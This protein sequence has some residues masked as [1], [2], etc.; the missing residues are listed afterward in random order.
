MS[1]QRLLMLLKNYFFINIYLFKIPKSLSLNLITPS[2]S[3]IT[4]FSLNKI[5]CRYREEYETYKIR[6]FVKLDPHFFILFIIKPA[7]QR[8]RRINPM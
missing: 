2:I 7:E 6:G 4:F 5:R 8:P 1:K 3:N